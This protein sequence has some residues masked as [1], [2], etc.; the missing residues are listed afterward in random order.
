MA[1][2]VRARCVG[3]LAL[4]VYFP[5]DSFGMVDRPRQTFLASGALVS[6]QKAAWLRARFRPIKQCDGA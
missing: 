5:G 1:L 2:A 3:R 6:G 4:C